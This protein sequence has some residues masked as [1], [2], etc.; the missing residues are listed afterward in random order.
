MHFRCIVDCNREIIFKKLLGTVSFLVD[1]QQDREDVMNEI[2]M[3]MWTSLANY[4]T[5]RPFQ[6]WL[7]GLVSRQVQ[8]FRVKSWRRFRI[9]ERVRAFSREESHWDQPTVLMDKTNQM[10]SQS[11]QKLTDKQRT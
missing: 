9:F 11:I 4:D 1:H 8:R 2:C 5:N 10:I 7:H 6:F 3:Q